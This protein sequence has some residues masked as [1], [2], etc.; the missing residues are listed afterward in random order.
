MHNRELLQVINEREQSV[1]ATQVRVAA[2]FWQRFRG[3]MLTAEPAEGEGLLLSPCNSIH[4]MFMLYPIDA[5]FL[6]AGH[7][8]RALYQKLSPWFGLSSWHRDVSSVLELKSG[9]I[10]KTG[11]RIDDVLRMERFPCVTQQVNQ[12]PPKENEA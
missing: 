3:L 6:D 7:K 11:I 9:T 10:N 1:V 8:I 5:V 2:G 4:M 12:L